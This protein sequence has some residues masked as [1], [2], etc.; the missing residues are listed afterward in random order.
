VLGVAIVSTVAVS[1]S[2]DF[3]AS[4]EG[5]N[6]LVVL[7]EGFQ[8]PSWPA[9]SWR[10][11][12]SAGAPASPPAAPSTGG[13]ARGRSDLVGAAVRRA[14]PHRRLPDFVEEPSDASAFFDA[15]TWARLRQVKALYDP[16]DLF[17]GN[18]HIP[19][20]ELG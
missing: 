7:T 13:T 14:L 20:A 4:N 3:L 5:A 9:S 2:E 1:C 17:K 16:T 19:P 11:R 15:D 10:N 18:H 12:R 6:P 8:L